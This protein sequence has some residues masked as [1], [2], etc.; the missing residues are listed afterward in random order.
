MMLFSIYNVWPWVWFSPVDHS[1]LLSVEQVVLRWERRFDAVV[2]FS[3]WDL[4]VSSSILIGGISCAH[5]FPLPCRFSGLN[6]ANE[7]NFWLQ[8]VLLLSELSRFEQRII[9]AVK[10]LDIRWHVPRERNR[11]VGPRPGPLHRGRS[12]GF[13]REMDLRLRAPG[14]SAQIKWAQHLEAQLSK[15]NKEDDTDAMVS[16]PCFHSILLQTV[17]L[18]GQTIRH[19][20]SLRCELQEKLSL[21][22]PEIFLSNLDWVWWREFTAWCF[23]EQD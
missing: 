10:F 14:G 21:D 12:Q 20:S 23:N 9:G 15:W 8:R 11:R 13:I 18:S 4:E 17:S 1:T 7:E 22:G 5:L 2:L 3:I 6:I 19:G 16:L